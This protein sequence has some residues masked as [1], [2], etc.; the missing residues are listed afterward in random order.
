MMKAPSITDNEIIS[1]VSKVSPFSL[2]RYPTVIY[3]ELSV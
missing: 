1:R 3:E 2:T